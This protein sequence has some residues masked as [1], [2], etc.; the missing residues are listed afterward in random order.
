MNPHAEAAIHRK[1]AEMIKLLNTYLNHFPRHEK[2]GLCL[3]IRTAAYETYGF[4]IEA[5]KR[6]R[7]KTALGNLDVRHEQLR[8]L[9]NLAHELNYFQFKDGK[10]DSQKPE[11]LAN[12]RFMALS[13]LIDEI[14]RMI[15]G[16]LKS[17]R[18]IP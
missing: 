14:G 4:M 15:G 2:Y 1:F 7:K 5:Q 13:K 18:E 9:V 11:L 10:T 6:Y 3:Q 12:H 16:W 8:L 17:E